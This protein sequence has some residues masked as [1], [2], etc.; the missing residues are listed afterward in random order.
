MRWRGATRLG[1]GKS[2]QICH[3]T[4]VRSTQ[5]GAC[6]ALAN[7]GV[8]FPFATCLTEVSE[9]YTVLHSCFKSQ[10]R[11]GHTREPDPTHNE[12]KHTTTRKTA[13]HER[14]PGTPH[15]HTHTH[16]HTT[17]E[18]KTPSATHTRERTR[19]GNHRLR[20]L[21]R[22]LRQRL[23]PLPPLLLHLPLPPNLVKLEAGEARELRLT[24]GGIGAAPSP[25][26]R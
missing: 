5:L 16:T 19:Q 11:T 25:A 2:R 18:R 21:H 6:A 17:V 26:L 10:P 20:D 9:L 24:R 8:F 12:L 22:P 14:N 13:T 23:R 4:G 1:H 15:V 3:G 7:V